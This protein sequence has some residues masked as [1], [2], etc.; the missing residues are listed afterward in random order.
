VQ[1]GKIGEQPL[2]VI[3][4][5]R[6]LRMARH[7]RHLP[8]V[9]LGVDVLGQR[10]AFFLQATDFLRNI[11]GGIV[12]HKA[13]FFDLGFELGNRLLKVEEGGF[14]RWSSSSVHRKRDSR[15]F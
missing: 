9:E 7:L 5:I 10:L 15:G 6:P 12:L 3:E 11:Q 1:F 8:G 13:Q 4:R 2:H 14:H